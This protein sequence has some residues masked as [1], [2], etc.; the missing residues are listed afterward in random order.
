MTSKPPRRRSATAHGVLSDVS[1]SAKAAF[2]RGSSDAYDAV[3]QTL[4]AV[5]RSIAKG[6]YLSCYY[7]AFGAVY[8]AKL[9]MEFVPE[10]SVIRDGFRHGAEAGDEAYAQRLTALDDAPNYSAPPVSGN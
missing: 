9:A 5:K 6:I 8:G 4:P 10:D 7:L 2:R 3:E 1:D